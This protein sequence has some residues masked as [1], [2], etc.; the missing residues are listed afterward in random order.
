MPAPRGTAEDVVLADVVGGL[1]V[2]ATIHLRSVLTYRT[3]ART[4][5]AEHVKRTTHGLQPDTMCV[6]GVKAEK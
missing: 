1:R 4:Q 3:V 2:A 6:S 5:V